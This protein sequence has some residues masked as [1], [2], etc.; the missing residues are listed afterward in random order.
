MPTKTAFPEF[1]QNSGKTL[2]QVAAVFGVNKT[3]IIRWEKGVPPVPAKRLR[4]IEDVTG[5]SRQKLRP[6]LYEGIEA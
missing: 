5:I 2:E 1:R 6:D 4:E 3:T